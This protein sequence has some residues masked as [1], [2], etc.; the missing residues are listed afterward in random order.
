MKAM[1]V[2]NDGAFLSQNKVSRCFCRDKRIGLRV[3]ESERE[4]LQDQ[5]KLDSTLRYLLFQARAWKV[6]RSCQEEWSLRRPHGRA[7]ILTCPVCVSSI[8]SFSCCWPTVFCSS[9]PRLSSRLGL[10]RKLSSPQPLPRPLLRVATDP[11]CCPPQSTPKYQKLHA[12]LHSS[13]AAPPFVSL[14]HW[15]ETS[16]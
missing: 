10:G 13:P 7:T 11:N 3:Q 5:R 14:E 15:K 2:T 6:E 12:I 16:N 8:S 4:L 1:R 9:Y